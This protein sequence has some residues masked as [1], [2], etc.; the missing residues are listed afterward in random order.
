MKY[1]N[2]DTKRQIVYKK[3]VEYNIYKKVKNLQIWEYLIKTVI[4]SH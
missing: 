3:I 4:K 1:E 2:K